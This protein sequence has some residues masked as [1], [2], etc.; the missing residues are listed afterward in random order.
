MC[1]DEPNPYC[2]NRIKYAVEEGYWRP[3]IWKVDG[4][5]FRIKRNNAKSAGQRDNERNQSASNY[6]AKRWDSIGDLKSEM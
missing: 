1:V 2:P 3:K 5:W 4:K 6:L